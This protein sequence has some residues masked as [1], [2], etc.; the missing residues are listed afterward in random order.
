MSLGPVYID[1][2]APQGTLF[3][4]FVYRLVAGYRRAEAPSTPIL[5]DLEGIQARNHECQDRRCNERQPDDDILHCL[6]DQDTSVD[7]LIFRE[8]R[9]S[10]N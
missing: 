3:I 4:G 10:D 6:A 2:R 5:T 7:R 8:K 9:L 1:G